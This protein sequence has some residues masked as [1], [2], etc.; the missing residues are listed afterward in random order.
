MND[1]I[2][3]SDALK[4]KVMSTPK[5]ELLQVTKVIGSTPIKIESVEIY[6]EEFILSN[7]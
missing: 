7:F 5:G 1:D 2:D 4:E 6:N 3:I